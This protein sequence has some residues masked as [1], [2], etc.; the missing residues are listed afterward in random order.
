[1]EISKAIQASR[2][3]LSPSSVKTYTSI[4][5][6]LHRK[7][8]GADEIDLANFKDTK[9]IL[10]FLKDV[11]APKRKTILSSLVV[12]TGLDEFRKQMMHDIGTYNEVVKS[13]V[14][15]Q[16]QKE[17]EISSEQVKAVYDALAARAAELYKKK[18]PTVGDLLQIQDFIL[19]A[20]MSGEFIAPRRSLDWTAFKIK[21]VDRENDN[22]LD[23]NFLTFNKYKTAK[24]SGRQEVACPAELKKILS[25]WMKT[26]PTDHLLFNSK[27]QSLTSPQI[28][29]IFNRIFNGKKVSTNQLRHSFLTGKFAAYSKEQKVVADTMRNMGS[30]EAVLNSYVRF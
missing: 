24:T 15:S 28:T 5:G 9:T 23:K 17:S 12:L 21:N 26:N 10:A 29:Q 19:L 22:Y 1:M 25:K 13:Q 27:L 2:P 7:I 14:M 3:N 11:A 6:S 30:S 18:S 16:K 4:L 8:W 20:L